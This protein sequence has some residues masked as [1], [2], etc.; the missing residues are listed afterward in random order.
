MKHFYSSSMSYDGS[1]FQ[2][3]DQTLLP[4]SQKWLVCDDA[5]TLIGM[6]GRLAI[7][8]APAIGISAAILLALLAERGEERQKLLETA[9]LLKKSRPTA[10]NLRNNVDQITAAIQAEN[11]PESVVAAAERIYTED[12]ELCRRIACLG[13]GLIRPGDKIL[14]HCNTGSLATAGCGTAMGILA[15]AHRRHQNIFVWVDE[16]RPLLQGARLTAWECGS[17][18]IEHSIIC[19]SAAAYLMSIRQVDR[20]FVGSD[21]IA[22]NGDFANKIGTYS[23]AVLA[24]YHSIPFY[25]AAPQTTVDP[26]CRDGMEIPIELRE[27]SEVKGVDTQSGRCTWSPAES[28]AHNPAFDITPANLVTAW[29]LDSGIF[30]QND[31]TKDDWWQGGSSLD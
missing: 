6:I 30:W 10:V 26:R 9:M 15:E 24:K 17:Y 31:V 19:D 2:I 14:T 7:R 13:A 3:L 28:P 23:L 11:Y 27:E 16:T 4:H 20:I 18:G 29:I 25:V 22:Y 12:I 5:E 21:R 1:S 8:G